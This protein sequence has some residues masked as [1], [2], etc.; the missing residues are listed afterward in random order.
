MRGGSLAATTD[1]VLGGGTSNGKF[2]L[3]DSSAVNSTV[4]S[5]QTYGF[6]ATNA[7]VGGA[8]T[9]STL[10]LAGA[11]TT[12]FPTG[13]S[14]FTAGVLGGSGANENNLAVTVNGGLLQLGGSNTYIGDTR[15]ASG[16][17][18]A[19][20][21]ADGGQTSSLGAASSAIILG[22]GTSGAVVATLRY[23]GTTPAQ[24]NR[25]IDI[26]NSGAPTSITAQ[27]DSSGLGAVQFTSLFVATGSSTTARTLVLTGSNA[28][29]NVIQGIGD[30]P[31]AVTNLE[32]TGTGKWQ[33]AGASTDT[34]F[35]HV[36]AGTL[37][38]SGSISGTV[39]V[40]D[41]SFLATAAVLAGSGTVG[42]VVA[43]GTSSPAGSGADVSPGDTT[44]TAGILHTGAFSLT[45]GAHLDLEIGGVTAGGN[46]AAGY[47]QIVTSGTL[48][49]TGGDLKLTLLGT[50]T[51]QTGNTLF[52][53]INNSGSAMGGS[54]ATLNGAAFDPTGFFLSGQQFQL[55]YGANY[56]GAGS[57]GLSNDLAL[58]A[59]PE[60]GA[61]ASLL[62]GLTMLALLRRRQTSSH[63]P[64][65]RGSIHS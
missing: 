22:S 24:T 26:D 55:V 54:F 23:V 29:A 50:P 49:F 8:S 39:T 37:V 25:A 4:N 45:A 27:I 15:I 40:G 62:G 48:D 42:D 64:R 38:V 18:E 59:I 2:I 60:P 53:A 65:S 46:S 35:V 52:L 5:I 33:L 9:I 56:A 20:V 43:T 3:G 14:V 21:L 28:G 7:I 32:K 11:A 63:S 17:I 36:K 41:P 58:V 44:G 12:A 16:T 6:G 57:D 51:F 61:G 47:D 1:I 19:S 30:A 31:G 10:T 13:T 34:G